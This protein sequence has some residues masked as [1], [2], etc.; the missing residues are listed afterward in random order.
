MAQHKGKKTKPDRSTLEREVMRA[1]RGEGWLAPETEEEV[2]ETEGKL[3]SERITMP[4]SLDHPREL[5]HRPIEIRTAQSKLAPKS[6]EVEENLARAA[7]EG[8]KISPE[9]EQRMKR[10]RDAAE[11]GNKA[12]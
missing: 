7:R 4:T 12:K 10:D 6:S 11:S 9:V 8:G 3:A 2:L 5:L 1:M